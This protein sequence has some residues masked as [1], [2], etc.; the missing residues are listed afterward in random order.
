MTSSLGFYKIFIYPFISASSPVFYSEWFSVSETLSKCPSLSRPP[1]RPLPSVCKALA[2]HLPWNRI[3]FGDLGISPY[4]ML[5]PT[6]KGRYGYFIFFYEVID[7]ER[8]ANIFKVTQLISGGSGD[9][10]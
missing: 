6:F 10:Y 2:E 4:S 5:S 8:L 7:S 9:F 1:P 3:C